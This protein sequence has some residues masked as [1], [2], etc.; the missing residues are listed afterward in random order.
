MNNHSLSI[1][2][3]REKERFVVVAELKTTWDGKPFVHKRRFYRTMF[4]C[5]MRLKLFVKRLNEFVFNFIENPKNGQDDLQRVFLTIRIGLIPIFKHL[6]RMYLSQNFNR[7]S[8][9]MSNINMLQIWVGK[10]KKSNQ[11]FS[12]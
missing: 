1:F 6:W 11:C 10:V 8:V 5:L 7:Y 2:I 12:S 3:Y 9:L 4:V